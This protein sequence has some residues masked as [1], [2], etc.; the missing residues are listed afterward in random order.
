LISN[1][2]SDCTLDG[3]NG[4]FKKNKTSKGPVPP[5]GNF[6][7]FYIGWGLNSS[8]VPKVSLIIAFTIA[9]SITL[10]ELSLELISIS[11]SPGE[12]GEN[13]LILSIY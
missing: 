7:A 6:L 4:V 11:Y 12:G 1:L 8:K 5:A 3:G 9:L 13:V 10:L 2:P